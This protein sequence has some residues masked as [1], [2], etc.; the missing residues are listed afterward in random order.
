MRGGRGGRV[1]NSRS[2]APT[3]ARKGYA[4]AASRRES[5]VSLCSNRPSSVSLSHAIPCPP[6]SDRSYQSAALRSVNA[7][8]SSLSTATL[9]PPL[10][11]ARDITKAFDDV[12][13]RL[14]WPMPVGVASTLEDDLPSI[15]SNLRCPVKLSKSALKAPGTPHSW[16]PLLAALH[17]LVQ[18]ARFRDYR[19]SSQSFAEGNNVLQYHFQSFALFMEGDDEAVKALDQEQF[20]QTEEHVAKLMATVESLEKE[21]SDLEKRAEAIRSG[22]SPRETTEKERALLKDDIKKFDVMIE[23]WKEKLL[24][25]EKLLGEKEEGLDAK[26]R[27]NQRIS[28]ENEELRKRIGS[29]VMN[30]RDAERTKKELQAMERDVAEAEIGRNVLE[31]KSWE[32]EADIDRKLKELESLVE[33][34]NHTIKKLKL[35][36]DFQYVLK[37]EG[38]SAAEVLGEDYKTVLKP[39]LNEAADETKKSS[40]AKLEEKI[41]LQQQ[42][43]EKS[44]L[45][46]ERKELLSILQKKIDEAEARSILL[47]RE[48]DDHTSRCSAE[49]ER[50]MKDRESREHQLLIMEE[51]AEN[52][53][54]DSELKLQ[55]SIR[56]SDEEIQMCASELVALIDAV[57]EYKECMESLVGEIQADLS[58]TTQ[59]IVDAHKAFLSA[60]LMSAGQS[61]S[62]CGSKR[63]HAL[64]TS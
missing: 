38:S 42:S 16:P 64:L 54:K 28:E 30:V 59:A 10:P 27:E 7:Y 43:R 18:L 51:E 63:A 48:V 41:Y 37:A 45:L 47:K 21:A 46:D 15:L 1:P 52:F 49:A 40:V 12:L 13:S 56:E 19:S 24:S 29:Q 55:K 17:W 26:I 57:S 44:I 5:D 35:G 20:R 4:A 25:A 23:S 39:F 62:L 31:E 6:I 9:R 22:P 3:P 8:L 61:A 11:S 50:M 58:E 32:L 53:L 2:V 60:R 33:Q 34:A 36:C 14:D